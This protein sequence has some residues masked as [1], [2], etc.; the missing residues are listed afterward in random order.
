VSAGEPQPFLAEQLAHFA[1]HADTPP[2][3]ALAAARMRLLDGLAVALAALPA[4]SVVRPRAALALFGCDG[5]ASAIGRGQTCATAAAALHNGLL[6]HGLEFDDTHLGAV[7]HGAPVV[8]PAVLACAEQ[9][10][11]SGASV[12]RAIC[13][14]WEVLARIGGALRGELQRFGFQ[15]TSVAGPLAAAAAV[16]HLYG[17]DGRRTAH[18]LGIAGSQSSGVFE[19]LANGATSKALHGGWAAL[20]GLV[21]AS[22][23]A[24]GMTG[25]P[26]ILEGRS[27]LF[28]AFARAPELA[29]RMQA[30]L[31]D[32]G[33]RWAVAETR[34]KSAPCC[35]YIQA[36]LE[37]LEAVLEGGVSASEIRRI[38]CIV[39]PR[40]AQLICEPWPQKLAPPTGYAAKWSL[41]FCLAARALGGPV[42]V[43]LFERPLEP[44]VLAF[45][46]RID[47]SAQED[48]FPERYPGR[49]AVTLADGRT[50]ES[51]VPDV[52]GA[53]GRAFSEEALMRK[54]QEAAAAVLPRADADALLEEVLDLERAPSLAS[55]GRRLRSAQARVHAATPHMEPT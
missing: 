28:S 54:F 16:S 25:P 7:V 10:E 47:W 9:Q 19:F 20:G 51:Y 2:P 34:P 40:Q 11:L 26:S 45:A 5:P 14:G 22:L 42:N 24:D 46:Q 21:A 4:A 50:V 48:G 3:A 13:V 38:R 6:M 30:Q 35:H 23:A 41:P 55:L 36:F 39:D 37:A 27:G 18:A 12:L 1:A 44:Q 43:E 17:F 52:L 8:L 29:A 15:A 49:L 32:L 33:E 31:A 53:P